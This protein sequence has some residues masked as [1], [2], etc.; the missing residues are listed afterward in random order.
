MGFQHAHPYVALDFLSLEVQVRLSLHAACFQLSY[1]YRLRPFLLPG[2]GCPHGRGPLSSCQIFWCLAQQKR[3][4]T[5]AEATNW[6]VLHKGLAYL[7]VTSSWVFPKIGVPQNGWFMMENPIKVD[8][9]GGKPTILGN[10]HLGVT[11][12]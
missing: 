2:H 8:D 3:R 7:G 5:E 12:S 10:P 6:K 4:T 9:L 11:S 1:E